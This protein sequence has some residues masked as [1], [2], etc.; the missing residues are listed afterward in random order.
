MTRTEGQEARPQ[1]WPGPG[2]GA[3]VVVVDR[4]HTV[5][6]RVEGDAIAQLEAW[7]VEVPGVEVPHMSAPPK[8]GFHRGTGGP[9]ATD[10]LQRRAEHAVER[11]LARAGERV[12][13]LARDDEWVLVT[14]ERPIAARL[15]R[16]LGPRVRP[17]AVRADVGRPQTPAHE[18]RDAVR[19][20]LELLDQRRTEA[21][22]QA[23]LARNAGTHH[24]G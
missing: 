20:E 9:A 24:R 1:Q 4:Q 11:N 16:A 12:R 18:V 22:L 15:H 8:P 6:W 23:A 7:D 5:L 13:A 3:L 17:R 14:G 19:A 10:V 2:A 21:E